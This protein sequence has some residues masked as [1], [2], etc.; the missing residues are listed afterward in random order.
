LNPA[1]LAYRWITPETCESPILVPSSLKKSQGSLS[2]SGNFSRQDSRYCLIRSAVSLLTV[3]TRL[4]IFLW[5]LIE[6][7]WLSSR[8]SP[9]VRL[10]ISPARMEY[11][12][13]SSRIVLSLSPLFVT[14]STESTIFSMSPLARLVRGSV[15]GLS[16]SS[17]EPTDPG[18]R[19]PLRSSHIKKSWI[20][21]NRAPVSLFA[22][23]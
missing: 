2:A 17:T 10:Q 19:T 11:F 12:E 5:L 15:A 3:T 14:V 18:K 22:F 21:R 1:S 13:R 16:G 4:S 7:D 20:A 8:T 6:T 9:S 23:L